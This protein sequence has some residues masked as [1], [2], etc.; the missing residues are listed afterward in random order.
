MGTQ[1]KEMTVGNLL[2]V[3]LGTGKFT[4]CTIKDW[5]IYSVYN[6]ELDNLI[7]VQLKLD[8]LHSCTI[9]N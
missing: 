8:N 5:I 3:Q 7:R 4:L 2:R 1:C 9:K 6:L